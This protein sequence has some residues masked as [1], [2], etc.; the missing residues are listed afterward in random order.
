MRMSIENRVPGQIPWGALA[1]LPLFAMPYGGWLVE[2]GYA[3][4][5]RCALKSS[6]GV[7]CLTC[8]STRATLHLL[9]GEF[10]QALAMQPLTIAVYLVVAVVGLVSLALFV[11]NKHAHLYYTRRETLA[12][13]ATMIVLPI[14]AW[15]YLYMA[16]I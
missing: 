10:G 12:F 8:G 4:F 11:A 15:V 16:G 2:Q 3:D 14:V 5:G 13:K 9:H 1:M 7:P 6:L